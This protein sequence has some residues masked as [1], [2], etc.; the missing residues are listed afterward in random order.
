MVLATSLA[1][2]P[3]FMKTIE[4]FREL[5]DD[6]VIWAMEFAADYIRA[7][8]RRQL[9]ITDLLEQAHKPAK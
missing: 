3:S 9:Q 6:E 1:T 8:D 7:R 2:N 4:R 5:T